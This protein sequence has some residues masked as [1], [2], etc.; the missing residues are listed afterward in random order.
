MKNNYTKSYIEPKN[1]AK[2]VN[3]VSF[4]LTI[5]FIVFWT[6]T[7]VI[8]LFNLFYNL[9]DNKNTSYTNVKSVANSNDIIYINYEITANNT[10]YSFEVPLSLTNAIFTKF[11]LSDST[12]DNHLLGVR[13]F[14]PFVEDGPP[15]ATWIFSIP[16]GTFI[17]FNTIPSIDFYRYDT[18]NWSPSATITINYNSLNHFSAYNTHY[19]DYYFVNNL[20]IYYIKQ[21]IF[22]Y[23]RHTI[24]AN[25]YFSYVTWNEDYLINQYATTILSDKT[26][27]DTYQSGYDI[28]YYK[29]VAYDSTHD[30]DYTFLGLIGSIVDAPLNAVKDMLNFNLLGINLTAFL[31]G[32][33]TIS[34]IIAVVRLI[35]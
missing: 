30:Y 18:D 5:V 1:K 31:Q 7:G 2:K 11:N 29:G 10:D 9:N 27:Q 8:S 16:K 35:I 34:L 20:P 14:K 3:K 22:I 24:D 33:L 6:L 4:V 21:D 12:I 28:G 19:Y 23:V 32:L 25:S 15:V 17:A 13:P 26:F